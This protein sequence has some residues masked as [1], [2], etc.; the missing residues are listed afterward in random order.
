MVCAYNQKIADLCNMNKTDKI[1]LASLGGG[2][3]FP[4]I[5]PKCKSIL[6]CVDLSSIV[7]QQFNKLFYP[8]LKKSIDPN[9]TINNDFWNLIIE[10]SKVYKFR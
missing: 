10:L 2:K 4:A 9:L 1:L 5:N 8:I 7:I 6:D 3:I